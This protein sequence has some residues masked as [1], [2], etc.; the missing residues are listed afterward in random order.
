MNNDISEVNNSFKYNYSLKKD[1]WN[2]E[3]W[4]WEREPTRTLKIM[5]PEHYLGY[6]DKT[7]DLEQVTN[8]VFIINGQADKAD[9]NFVNEFNIK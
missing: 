6:K 8:E 1:T 4:E 9:A 3:V 5:D 2:D 7:F